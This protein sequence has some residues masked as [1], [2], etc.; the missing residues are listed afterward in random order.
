MQA[1]AEDV[2]RKVAGVAGEIVAAKTVALFEYQSSAEFEQVC[3]DNYDE[4]VRAFMYNVWREHP[5]WDLSFLGEV[6]REMI[7]EFNAP[8]ETPLN[9]PPTEFVPLVD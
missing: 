7:A 9:D 8:L 3:V 6:A 2:E 1:Q 4:G 5:E